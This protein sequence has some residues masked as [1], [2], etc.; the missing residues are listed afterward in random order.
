MLCT[1]L[2]GKK[3]QYYMLYHTMWLI[4][5]VD[6][7]R[8]ICEKP[9][10]S[11]RITKWQVLLVEYNI[12]YMTRK[13]VKGRAIIDHLAD[14]A[15]EDYEPLDFDFPD[16]NVLLIEEKTRRQIGGPCTLMGQ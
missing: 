10:L 11:N 12:V 4:S 1:G 5:M 3:L 14:K 15:I 7:L 9:Y 6:P 2:G 8:Y 13:V 16:E